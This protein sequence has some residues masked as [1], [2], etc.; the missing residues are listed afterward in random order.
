MK[1]ILTLAHA[2]EPNQSVVSMWDGIKCTD[3]RYEGLDRN[4]ASTKKVRFYFHK[5]PILLPSLSILF[6]EWSA[7]E[8]NAKRFHF[9]QTNRSSQRPPTSRILKTDSNSAAILAKAAKS[10]TSQSSRTPSATTRRSSSSPT[11]QTLELKSSRESKLKEDRCHA[12][13]T[14]EHA[15]SCNDKAVNCTKV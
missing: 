15:R 13:Q 6:F 7:T 2:F 8:F 5:K 3:S 10:G 12:E 11:R 9:K 4:K 14:D 1:T